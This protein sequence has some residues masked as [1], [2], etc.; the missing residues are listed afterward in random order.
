M[1]Y[2]ETV[3]F[4]TP[5]IFLLCVKDGSPFEYLLYFICLVKTPRIKDSET[6]H[7]YFMYAFGSKASSILNNIGGSVNYL[8]HQPFLM[9]FSCFLY[10]MPLK[11][12]KKCLPGYQHWLKSIFLRKIIITN[13][14]M[15]FHFLLTFAFG[16]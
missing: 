7:P 8:M 4:L 11:K 3:F 14:S 12:K 6:S 13:Y 2:A 15:H 9:F 5:R 16:R 1:F 10:F